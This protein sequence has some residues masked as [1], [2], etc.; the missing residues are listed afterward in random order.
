MRLS[1]HQM[2][3]LIRYGFNF[4]LGEIDAAALYRI[5]LKEARLKRYKKPGHMALSR[6]VREVDKVEPK[7]QIEI[8]KLK[9]STG[10]RSS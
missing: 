6:S 1:K 3:K 9:L 4:N 10:A 2:R 5:E 7:M 8:W